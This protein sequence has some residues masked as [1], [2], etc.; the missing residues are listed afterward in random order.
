M[1]IGELS[2]RTGLSVSAI[3]FYQRRGLL[4]ARDAGSS[5]QRYGADTLARLAVIGLAKST[6]FS[7][8]EIAELL[9]AL[10]AE[11]IPLPAWRDLAEGKL[12]EIDAQIA[13]LGD[14]RQLL[15]EALDC[16]CLSLDQAHLVPAALSWAVER[17]TA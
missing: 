12:T 5:W 3:R 16:S 4:P 13:R 2:R 17:T 15:T 8:D 7:L 11:E 1:T 10:D 6:G 14:M 9:G